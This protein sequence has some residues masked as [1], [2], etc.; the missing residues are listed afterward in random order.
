MAGARSNITPHI[1]NRGYKTAQQV[2]LRM[3]H[4]PPGGGA[5]AL[6]KQVRQTL[7][8]GDKRYLGLERDSDGVLILDANGKAQPYFSLAG[9]SQTASPG[10]AGQVVFV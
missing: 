9:L 1:F 8:G 10:V 7:G 3:Y 4:A 5:P 6:V 2:A